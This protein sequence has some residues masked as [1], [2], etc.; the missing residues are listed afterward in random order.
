MSSFH[1][2][3]LT[4]HSSLRPPL[5]P[6]EC[7]ATSSNLSLGEGGGEGRQRRRAEFGGSTHTST[8]LQHERRAGFGGGIRWIVRNSHPVIARSLR[9]SNLAGFWDGIGHAATREMGF[10]AASRCHV[11]NRSLSQTPTRRGDDSTSLFGGG[12]SSTLLRAS[13]RSLRTTSLP[14]FFGSFSALAPSPTRRR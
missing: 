9:R 6:D 1:S 10:A 7:E 3:Q 8:G 12:F 5:P 11:A 13:A 2:S 14:L 4:L